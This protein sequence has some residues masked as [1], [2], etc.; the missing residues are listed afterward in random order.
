[1]KEKGGENGGISKRQRF[2]KKR[3]IF[4]G[5][6]NEVNLVSRAILKKET[7]FEWTIPSQ[8]LHTVGIDERGIACYP[9]ST[10]K[11]KFKLKRYYDG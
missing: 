7:A 2:F 5:E 4:I 9:T 10:G 6:K 1:M 3:N 8:P 11:K